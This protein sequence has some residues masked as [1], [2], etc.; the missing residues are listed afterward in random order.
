MAGPRADFPRVVVVGSALP[1]LGIGA[2]FLIAPDAL[3]RCV[4][5]RLG[6]ATAANDLRAVHGGL[7]LAIGALLAGA[8]LSR[9]WLRAG[10]ALQ[11]ASFSGLAFGRLVSLLADGAPRAFGFALWGAELLGVA[12]G[13]VA[14]RARAS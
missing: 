9:E 1:F 6:S 10:L 5:L 11:L 4:D 7:E 14:W 13:V 3:G 8:G 2:A 12:L